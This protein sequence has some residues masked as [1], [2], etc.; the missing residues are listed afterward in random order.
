MKHT[1]HSFTMGPSQPHPPD[2][3]ARC[4][5]VGPRGL[6]LLLLPRDQASALGRARTDKAYQM[7]GIN[8]VRAVILCE[9][10]DGLTR[11]VAH[12]VLEAWG[13]AI[14]LGM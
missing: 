9:T 2:H 7:L 13:D 10:K 4:S 3:G 8:E 12:Y 1:H 11:I 6:A 14:A 5:C